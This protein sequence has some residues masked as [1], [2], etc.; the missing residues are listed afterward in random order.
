MKEIFKF[1]LPGL[2][3]L[4]TLGCN[5]K[6]GSSSSESKSSSAAST[7]VERGKTIYRTQCIACHNVDPHKAGSLGPE[8]F[9]SSQELLEARILRSEYPPGYSPKRPS[10]LMTAL[11]HLK[12]ELEAIHAYLNSKE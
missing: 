5:S 8:V 4:A 10:H 1:S 6:S 9:G 12:P 11:P 3:V 7:R 2:F